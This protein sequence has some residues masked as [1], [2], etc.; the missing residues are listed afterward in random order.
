MSL[1]ERT[2][3]VLDNMAW[4]AL[5]G[6]HARF[7]E[8]DGHALRYRRSMA[9]FCATERLDV[10]GWSA[11]TDLVGPGRAVVLFQPDIGPVPE[12]LDELFR[13]STWQMVADGPMSARPVRGD[14][15]EIVE[16]GAED[17]DEM[18]ALTTLTEPGPF[19]DETYRLGT[20]LGI[21]EGGRLV[22]M[23]G[24]RLRT[25]TVAEISAVC[26]HPDVRR[27]GL[28][29]LLTMAM[30]DA[31]RDRGQLAMLHVATT[32]APAIPLYEAL[33]FRIRRHVEAVAAR[34]HAADRS[35]K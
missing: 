17:V 3:R 34:V 26:T 22:A 10:S 28:G 29:G 6:P 24:E 25:E 5:T 7:A 35:G 4:H 15:V 30:A 14:S 16:L 23:A 31:I 21:R 27:R 9:V 8:G 32:N 11:L 13:T 12:G 20:Y 1:D 19:F 2:E 33:G 18:L